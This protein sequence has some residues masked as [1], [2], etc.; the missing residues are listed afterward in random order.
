M[1][2]PGTRALVLAAG[3]GERMRPLTLVLPKPLLPLA[4]KPM[5]V[6]V[7]ERAMQSGATRVVVAT[8]DELARLSALGYSPR[9]ALND[10]QAWVDSVL[11]AYRTYAQVC[12]TMAALA[13]GYPTICRLETLGFSVQNRAILMMRVT[14]NP[15]VEEAEPE[16][17]IVGPHHGDEKIASEVTLRQRAQGQRPTSARLFSSM[18]TITTRS[19]R[20]AGMVARR[21]A[22]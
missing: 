5:I 4:G 16:F 22:S 20:V 13:G 15:Q 14:D 18:S 10:Y 9:V 7:A 17:R 8:D 6:R 3:R 21:R 1:R 11:L 2:S 12:S 19:S